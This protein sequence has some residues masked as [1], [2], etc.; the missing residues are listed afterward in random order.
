MF[1]IIISDT[2]NIIINIYLVSIF[3]TYINTMPKE[4]SMSRLSKYYALLLSF[5]AHEPSGVD[6][7][8]LSN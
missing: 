2:L 7:V 6:N 1:G 8:S 5:W 3:D 4:N